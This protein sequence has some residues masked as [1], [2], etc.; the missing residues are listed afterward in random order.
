MDDEDAT[1]TVTLFQDLERWTD[2]K[3]ARCGQ[4]VCGHQVLYSVFLGLRDSPIC[5]AC[6][7]RRLER[8]PLELRDDLDQ[9]LQRRTCYR[10]AWDEASRQ[11]VPIGLKPACLQDSVSNDFSATRSTEPTDRFARRGSG[12]R[13]RRYLGRRNDGVWRPSVGT[14]NSH[15]EVGG[16]A[17]LEGN[18]FGPRGSGR[19]AGLVSSD[20]KPVG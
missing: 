17:G 12:I 14:P 2:A 19:P 7:A 5:S 4:E 10:K 18:C 6:A 13:S 8:A 3:C 16:R 1:L 9:H 20:R 11:G 15:G